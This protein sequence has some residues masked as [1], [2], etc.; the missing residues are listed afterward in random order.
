MQGGSPIEAEADV[1][2]LLFEDDVVEAVRH[3]LEA[4]GF[5]IESFAKATEHGEDIV[6]WRSGRRLSVE[7]KGEGS[8]MPH[9]NR[10]GKAFSR[11]QVHDHVGMAILK[12]LRA[13]SKGHGA[14]I[15]L[16]DN[17]DHRREVELVSPALR[18][19]QIGVYW[20]STSPN[21]SV[22]FDGDTT[23]PEVTEIR[24][25][26][27]RLRDFADARDWGEYHTPKNLAMALAGEAGE[28]LAEF[29]WLTA[30]ESFE[31]MKDAVA[32]EGV[33]DEVA[34]V[35]IYLLRLADLLEVDLLAAAE[36]KLARN[37]VRFPA[38]PGEDAL[39]DAQLH[40]L[41]RR[42]W[43][44]ATNETDAEGR[45][46]HSAGIKWL[47]EAYGVMV[48]VGAC[49]RGPVRQ[50][51]LARLE[52]LGAIERIGGGLTGRTRSL[53]VADPG[54]DGPQ[55]RMAKGSHNP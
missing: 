49:P 51:A 39:S 11:G 2:A 31:V 48:R 21:R 42:V 40:D 41:W 22:A 37:E 8:S 10:F 6:A 24:H 32:A 14:A 7:A 34:D 44:S 46:K 35:A 43:D 55:H 50:D 26:Q 17:R 47:L 5:V 27:D 4:E 28:L 30:E 52:A 33:T 25:L 23:A 20:V 15:A 12:A 1:H 19:A 3:F 53:W 36:A 9:T 54:Q 29:Q 18:D 38:A 13:K 45:R 16:P